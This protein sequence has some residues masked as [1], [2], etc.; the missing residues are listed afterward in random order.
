MIPLPLF[1]KTIKYCQMSW[2]IKI[3]NQY[4]GVVPELA[5]RAHQKYCSGDRCSASK[6]KYTKGYQ[7][8]TARSWTHGF[9]AGGSS[10]AKSIA[11]ALKIP[12]VVN[13]MQAC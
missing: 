1:Y 3:H 11:L 7:Q 9:I 8:F 13:H 10:F 6:S 4:G 2:R 12:L 5:S